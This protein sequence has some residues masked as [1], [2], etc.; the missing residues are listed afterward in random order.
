MKETI[1]QLR[2][3]VE[4][5]HDKFYQQAVEMA[6]KVKVD[7]SV[8]RTCKVQTL[9]ENYP[10]ETPRDYYRFKLTIPLLDHLK[11]EIEDR[12]P[13]EMCNLYNG[14]YAVPSILLSCKGVCWKTEFL[15]FL[16]AYKEDMPSYREVSSERKYVGNPLEEGD[17]QSCL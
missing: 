10:A 4:E 1:N 14:F 15:K 6:N 7:E 3:N 13:P 5:I 9:R 16:S 17:W 12:F 2:A 11:E 8:P